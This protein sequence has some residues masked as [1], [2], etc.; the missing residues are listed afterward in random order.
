[1]MAEPPVLTAAHLV[2]PRASG[3]QL[4]PRAVDGVEQRLARRLGL[5][6]IDDHPRICYRHPTCPLLQMLLQVCR[7]LRQDMTAPEAAVLER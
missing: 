3:R 5:R 6:L 2:L 1:M 7:V 4:H